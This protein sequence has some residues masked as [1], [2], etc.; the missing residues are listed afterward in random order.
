MLSEALTHVVDDVK[1]V[2]RETAVFVK[3]LT[4]AQIEH[5]Q[6]DNEYIRAGYRRYDI[7]KCT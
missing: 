1:A 7:S 5:W 2:E 4:W 3:T 6:R